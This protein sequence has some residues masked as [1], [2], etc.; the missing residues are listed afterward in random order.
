MIGRTLDCEIE[1]QLHTVFRGG[2]A[3]PPEIIER[4]EAG[5]NGVVPALGTADRVGTAWV[6]RFGAWRIVATLSVGAPDWVNRRK[7]DDVKTHRADGRQPADHV[8]EGA[9][10]A[11]IP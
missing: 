8:I 10:P 11:D 5:M 9:V 3:H 7:I 4:A 6:A 1:R 2:V